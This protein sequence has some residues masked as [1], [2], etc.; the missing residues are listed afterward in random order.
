MFN[1]LLSEP[2]Q[3]SLIMS[4]LRFAALSANLTLFNEFI[5]PFNLKSEI[6]NGYFINPFIVKEF[7]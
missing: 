4:G 7:S 5:I 6:L 1:Q 2:M 3:Q